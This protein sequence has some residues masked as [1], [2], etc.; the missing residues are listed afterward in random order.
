MPFGTE[1]SS[2]GNLEHSHLHHLHHLHVSHLTC[3]TCQSETA[4]LYLPCT[5]RMRVH[6]ILLGASLPWLL[7]HL[8]LMSDDTFIEDVLEGLALQQYLRGFWDHGITTVGLTRKLSDEEWRALVED[9]VDHALLLMKCR[10]VLAWD[11]ARR[12]SIE[13][14]SRRH[15]VEKDLIL[16]GSSSMD[17]VS[18]TQSVQLRTP[19]SR[20]LAALDSELCTNIPGRLDRLPWC[21]WHWVV[22]LALGSA[23]SLDGFLVSLNS[24]VGPHLTSTRTM[25]ITRFEAAAIGS[26]YISGAVLGCWGFGSLADMYG[27][28]R[29]FVVIPGVYLS[30]SILASFCFEYEAFVACVFMM[31]IGIG[32]EYSALNSA[33]NE[34]IP[35]RV[36]GTVDL[37]VNGTY[38]VGACFAAVTSK[39]PTAH[40][41]CIVVHVPNLSHSI[42]SHLPTPIEWSH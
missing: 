23:W 38:W 41:R 18:H 8:A 2:Y 10:E 22:V 32:G 11:D 20:R 12:H 16:D 37:V 29:L 31:G 4:S 28:K 9:P 39:V 25:G 14:G 13:T 26:I 34:F 3:H 35:A 5:Q 33:L 27:R 19:S 7:P 24:L 15:S 1:A 30:A 17:N 42:I 40:Y 21:R 6:H 36:R